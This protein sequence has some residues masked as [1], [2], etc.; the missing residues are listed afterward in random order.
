MPENAGKCSKMR[1]HAT[2]IPGAQAALCSRMHTMLTKIALQTHKK[3]MC[4]SIAA[5]FA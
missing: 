3:G 2:R 4:G 5:A 1:K